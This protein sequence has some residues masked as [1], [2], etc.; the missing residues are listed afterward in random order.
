MDNVTTYGLITAIL[1][2]LFMA[3]VGYV[4]Y[5]KNIIDSRVRKFV[6]VFVVNVSSPALIF[7][8][9][10]QNFSY[11]FRPAWWIFVLMSFAFFAFGVAVT[12]LSGIFIG[13]DKKAELS[14]L[15]AFQNCGYLPMNIINLLFVGQQKDTLLIYIFLFLI[16]FNFLMW[17]VG[18]Y[19][20]FRKNSGQFKWWSIFTPPVISAMLVLLFKLLPYNV[21]VPE[22]VARPIYMLG[23]TTFV[24]SMIFLGAT[25]AEAGK[26]EFSKD[27]LKQLT[28]VIVVKLFV[29]P[30][31]ALT[32][33][34]FIRNSIGPLFSLFIVIQASVPPAVNTSLATQFRGG[35]Y[36][37][38]SKV[39][40]VTHFLAIITIP[41]W[42][43]VYMRFIR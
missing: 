39:V 41:L 7:Y 40:V 29:L 26:F 38:V 27:F 15:N 33:C 13:K 21:V 3:A 10:M 35:D 42:L 16:G 20:I 30:I 9:M 2:L 23:Q 36:K 25:L 6:G 28:Q 5:R 4:L 43:N 19:F 22:L 34:Y 12:K 31:I 8:S 17:S 37:F 18:S 1:Q 14:M 11:S 32:I 24:F